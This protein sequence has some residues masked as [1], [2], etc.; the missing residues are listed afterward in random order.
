M[1]HLFDSKLNDW[2]QCYWFCPGHA[3]RGPIL[4]VRS[5]AGWHSYLA[6]KYVRA[7]FICDADSH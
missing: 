3:Q 6:H 4:V 5:N 7:T 2:K 1:L